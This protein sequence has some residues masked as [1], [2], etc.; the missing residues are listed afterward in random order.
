[1]EV[2]PIIKPSL[3]LFILTNRRKL[4]WWIG[5]GIAGLFILVQLIF[6][7][8]WLLPY[9]TVDGLDVG[10]WKKADASWQLDHDYKNINLAM[11][12]GDNSTPQSEPS[13]SQ[14]GVT[15][16]NS[17]RIDNY[18]YAW[19]WRL[20][21]TSIFWAH[22]VYRDSG[23]DYQRDDQAR[24][25]YLNGLVGEDCHVAASNASLKADG[26]GLK[27]VPSKVGGS[28][29][30]QEVETSLST[31]EPRLGADNSIHLEVVSIDP[32][33]TNDDAQAL[34]DTIIKTVGDK[35]TIIADSKEYDI[36]AVD[37][38]SWLVFSVKDNELVAEVS[39]DKSK[40]YLNEHFASLVFKKPGTSHITTKNFTVTEQDKGK[41]GQ[42]I[43]IAKTAT[44]LTFAI[45]SGEKV[46]VAVKKVKPKVTYDRSYTSTSLGIEALMAH[47]AKDNPGTYGVAFHELSG[48]GRSAYYRE[49]AKYTTAST[50][51]MF[52][53]YSTI[54]RVDKGTWK[55]S[56]K[57]IVG[58]QNRG[59]CFDNMIVN[60]DNACAK[61]LLSAIGYQKI[62]DEAH[63]IG[64]T[65]TSFV[66]GDTP[67][68]TAADEAHF[69]V[70]L[71]RN[72]LDISKS[73]RSK[74]L[75]AMKKQV[76]RQGIPKGAGAP[77]ADKVGFLWDLLHDAAIV[78]SS[79]GDYVLVIMT[80]KSS[81]ANIA[82]LTSEIEA[83]R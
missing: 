27:V 44:N 12:F 4:A 70:Q 39:A 51:K 38:Y 76:Y 5:G 1:M 11:Y 18:S 41:S 57:N 17:K 24:V 71:A 40:D 13:L 35:V 30:R 72:K 2:P 8:S 33:V 80:D 45:N 61:A 31:I 16:T 65:D 29:D 64:C 47:F 15:A 82:K 55:W 43:D 6:P 34:A 46:E 60:S 66:S 63:D 69:L 36:T 77:V 25:A 56:D 78:Y 26:K 49:S 52:V 79:K 48:K 74:M 28:C 68:S 20:V 75:S 42:S 37:I 59:Q 32:A 67:S 62:T 83:L 21:P 9:T 3:K 81:W 23:P 19:Y 50:Y 53:A 54:K 22:A 58:S 10:G 7:G 14:T 73:G